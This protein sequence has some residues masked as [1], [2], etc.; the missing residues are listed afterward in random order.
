M[1]CHT[2]LVVALLTTWASS[3]DAPSNLVVVGGFPACGIPQIY[4]LLESHPNIVT[5]SIQIGALPNLQTE[6][7]ESV[8]ALAKALQVPS[9]HSLKTVCEQFK[10]Q[11]PTFRECGRLVNTIRGWYNISMPATLVV[12][13]DSFFDKQVGAASQKRSKISL[14]IKIKTVR[15]GPKPKTTSDRCLHH[16][17]R[18]KSSCSSRCASR[19][20]SY[21]QPTTRGRWPLLASGFRVF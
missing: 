7:A 10:S 5:F 6:F 19:R 8:F 11:A 17:G 4:S 14:A 3:F 12:T 2:A 1:W 20:T 9:D 16:A 18:G 13:D 21:G 15:S